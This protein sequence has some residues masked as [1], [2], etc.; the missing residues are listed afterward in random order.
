[1]SRA[2]ASSLLAAIA[3]LFH[4]LGKANRLFQDKL[5]G[6]RRELSEPLRHEWVSLRIFE[7]F[8]DGRDDRQW[9]T[10][11]SHLKPSDERLALAGLGKQTENKAQPTRANPF[12]GLAPGL[13]SR[14]TAC[15]SLTPSM[16][17]LSERLPWKG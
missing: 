1:M 2:I 10:A 3:G 14:T 6:K 12:E 13:S 5:T 8:V 11:L 15:H 7:A 4:D 17:R 9:L 16:N